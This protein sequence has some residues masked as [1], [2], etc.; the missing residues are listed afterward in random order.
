[1]AEPSLARVLAALPPASVETVLVPRDYT[2]RMF[3]TLWARP[4]EYLDAGVRAATSVWEQLPAE[5][6]E[7]AL[8]RLRRDLESGDW[9]RRYGHLRVLP[10]LDVGLRLVRAE[11]VEPAV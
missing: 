5:V 11:L 10:E 3:A 2:D 1:L 9:D 4:E 8:D 6:T 7:R